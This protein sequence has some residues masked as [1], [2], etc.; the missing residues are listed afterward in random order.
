LNSSGHLGFSV[1]IMNENFVRDPMTIHVL[2][3]FNHVCNF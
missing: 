3:V 2:F 1:D